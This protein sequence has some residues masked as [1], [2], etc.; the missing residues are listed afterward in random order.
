MSSFPIFKINY[1]I[2][3]NT[4]NKIVVFYGIHLDVDDPNQLFATDPLNEAFVNIFNQNELKEIS[5]KGIE[6]IF[7]NE[8]I[9]TDDT[10]GIIKLKIMDTFLKTFS[11]EE[12]YLYC[13][14]K[15]EIN[16][17][18]IYQNLTLNDKLPLTRILMDQL[19][20]NIRDENGN[21]IQFDNVK[22]KYTFDDI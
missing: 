2:D 20:L 4:I 9:Y 5:E 3:R 18:A 19:L 13:L 8:R 12:I 21:P 11:E 15:E 14:K 16:P 10:I 7:V 22:E 1:L 17:I 6:V